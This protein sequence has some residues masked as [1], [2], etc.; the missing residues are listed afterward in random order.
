MDE[1]LK[2]DHSNESYCPVLSCCALY[3]AVQGAIY[4][5]TID[6]KTFTH[7]MWNLIVLQSF[8]VFELGIQNSQ[9]AKL[10]FGPDFSHHVKLSLC[11]PK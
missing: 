5:A 3:Y 6:S 9:G 11:L 10:R 2:C 8:Q 7:R 1:I 4:Y